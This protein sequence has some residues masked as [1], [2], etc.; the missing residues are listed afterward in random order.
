MSRGVG[1]ISFERESGSSLH[2]SDVL[3]VLGLKKNLVL[4][5]TLEDKGYGVIFNRDKAYL[6]HLAF[7]L[8]K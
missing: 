5:A 6:K 3:Y 8:V 4:V 2:L 1:T 7:G